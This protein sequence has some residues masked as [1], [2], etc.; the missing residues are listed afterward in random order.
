MTEEF[1]KARDEGAKDVAGEWFCHVDAPLMSAWK[2]G[3]DWAYNHQQQ[4]IDKLKGAL[5]KWIEHP[6]LVHKYYGADAPLAD[7]EEEY[8]LTKTVLAEVDSLQSS[9]NRKPEPD[10]RDDNGDTLIQMLEE[11]AKRG[12]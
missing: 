7:V 2:A 6:D 11:S 9:V 10:S 5:E 12:E 1:K 4:I 8:A 3:A